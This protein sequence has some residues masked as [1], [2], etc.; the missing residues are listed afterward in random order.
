M[1]NRDTQFKQFAELLF[2]ELLA[3]DDGR[4]D[5]STYNFMDNEM[6]NT[7]R[8]IIAQRAYDLASHVVTQTT[9][10]AHGDMDKIPDMGKWPE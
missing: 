9:L 2:A 6:I 10:T 8:A 4:I 3:V 7:Y 1:S 5:V